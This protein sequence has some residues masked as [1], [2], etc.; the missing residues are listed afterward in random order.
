MFR[1]CK[2]AVLL[3]AAAILVSLAPVAYSQETQESPNDAA[4]ADQSDMAAL[5]ANFEAEFAGL[6]TNDLATTLAQAH[7]EV[8]LFGI[9]SPFPSNGKKEF[10]QAVQSYFGTYEKADFVPVSPQFRIVGTTAVSWGHYQLAATPKGGQQLSYSHGRYILTHVKVDGKWLIL[11]M[12]I[13]PLEPYRA[14]PF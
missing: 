4:Q 3:C 14:P 12:H 11:S 5:K 1:I 2:R 6:N 7:E 8:V 13:S 10:E 9:F